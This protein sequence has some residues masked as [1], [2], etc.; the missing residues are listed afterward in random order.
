M[1]S[2]IEVFNYTFFQNAALAAIFA[3]ISCG[4]IG[5]YIV[6]KRMVFISGGITHASFGGI[7]LGYLTGINPIFG[8]AGFAI[9]TAWAIEFFSKKIKIRQDS[10]IGIFWSLGMA[11]GII[12]VYLTPGYAPNL[13]SYLF[14][15][16]LAVSINELMFMAIVS[17]IAIM[18]FI[19]LY[20]FILF[21]A[22]DEEFAITQ[23]APVLFIN[24]LLITLIALTIVVNIRVVG[25]ILVISL[26]TIPQTTANLLSKNFKSII[27][28]SILI[29][30]IGSIAGLI[31]AFYLDIPS[32][33]SI[34]FTL[35]MVF[36]IVKTILHFRKKRNQ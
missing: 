4:I 15:S 30:L 34:I 16:I 29:S 6:S 36:V 25:I 28:L 5:T 21:I 17:L 13:I 32:G 24:Y 31:I 27:L 14:G 1:N 10:A 35:V 23:N 8:A 19:F 26:L 18:V 2:I 11:L 3:S 22:F 7:G 12:F 20:R 33:A 9:I